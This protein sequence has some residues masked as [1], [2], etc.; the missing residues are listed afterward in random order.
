MRATLIEF[1]KLVIDVAERKPW[2]KRMEVAGLNKGFD[3]ANLDPNYFGGIQKEYRLIELHS[4][5]IHGR[6]RTSR[7][8]INIEDSE[9]AFPILRAIVKERTKELENQ[10]IKDTEAML[11]LIDEIKWLR[12]PW[13]KKLWR[14][15]K[16]HY[17][18]Y[19]RNH[20]KTY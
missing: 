2:L 19:Q 11:H 8:Y 10:H 4:T 6:A 5:D 17:A 9:M 18:D 13:Y 1:K 12:L 20:K 3:T 14:S 7:Y 16:A 15:F